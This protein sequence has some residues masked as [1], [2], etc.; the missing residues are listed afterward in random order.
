MADLAGAEVSEVS[1][2]VRLGDS[3]CGAY[4][5]DCMRHNYEWSPGISITRHRASVC[6]DLG[7][8]VLL[9]EGEWCSVCVTYHHNVLMQLP[10]RIRGI[11]MSMPHPNIP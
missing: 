9:R 6:D 7:D 4:G 1:V 11:V 3:D 2:M 8:E 5:E 10:A